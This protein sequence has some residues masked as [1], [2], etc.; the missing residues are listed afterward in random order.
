MS[1]KSKSYRQLEVDLNTYKPAPVAYESKDS[2]KKDHGVFIGS[3]KRKD[4]TETERTPAPNQYLAEKANDYSST[5][6][7]RCAIGG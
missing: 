5:A 7:P 3:S 1:T 2:F 4:L 6:N